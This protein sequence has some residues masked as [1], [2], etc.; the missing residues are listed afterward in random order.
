LEQGDGPKTTAVELCVGR[1]DRDPIA[2]PGQRDE[3]V[4]CRA[5]E[6]DPRSEMHALAGGIEPASDYPCLRALEMR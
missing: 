6:R 2:D 1:N 5:F 3:G 4:R